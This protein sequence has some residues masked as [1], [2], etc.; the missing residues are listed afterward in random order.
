[1]SGLRPGGSG[2]K[3]PDYDAA[4]NAAL[5][6]LAVRPRSIEE[7]RR[8][9]QRRHTYE[10]I[11]KVISAL[12]THGLLDDA[13]YARQWRE[14]RERSRPRGKALLRHELLRRGISSDTAA[15]ALDGFDA[16]GNAYRAGRSLA[17]RLQG[18]DYPKFRQRIW[19]HLQRRGFE[20]CIIAETV[21]RLWQELADP[22]NSDE[23]AYD[24]K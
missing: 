16:A 7:V 24:E 21:T 15:T 6:F 10:V 1:M 18:S 9:L 14:Y 4:H 3:N 22:L 5:R 2:D 19:S 11:D 17:F 23:N 12:A 20:S 8:R 13:A